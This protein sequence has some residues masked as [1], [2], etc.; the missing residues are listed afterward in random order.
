VEILTEEEVTQEIPKLEFS[1]PLVVAIV[2][3]VLIYTTVVLYLSW[4]DKMVPDSLTYSFYAFFGFETGWLAL[5]KVNKIK[6]ETE[7]YY[8]HK[9]EIDR[10]GGLMSHNK[11]GK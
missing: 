2:L 10:G 4:H 8:R 6:R 9:E 11:E 1:K 5:I 3:T 7:V